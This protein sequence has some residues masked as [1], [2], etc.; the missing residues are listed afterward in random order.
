MGKIIINQAPEAYREAL[1]VG[2]RAG[3]SNQKVDQLPYILKLDEDYEAKVAADRFCRDSSYQDCQKFVEYL[4]SHGFSSAGLAK[5]LTQKQKGPACLSSVPLTPS[6]LLYEE[7]KEKVKMLQEELKAYRTDE[8]IPI[9]DIER[10]SKKRMAELIPVIVG[11]PDSA[12]VNQAIN[13]LKEHAKDQYFNVGMKVKMIDPMIE[14]LLGPCCTGEMESFNRQDAGEVLGVL[15]RQEITNEPKIRILRAYASLL[16]DEDYGIGCVEVK[17]LDLIKDRLFP[18]ELKDEIFDLLVCALDDQKLCLGAMHVISV[19]VSR[20]PLCTP[21]LEKLTPRAM[22]LLNNGD[23]RIRRS[24]AKTLRGI[25]FSN[26]DVYPD[27]G[28]KIVVALAERTLQEKD[29]EVLG[30]IIGCLVGQLSDNT[31]EVYESAEKAVLR[32]IEKGH[33]GV[34]KLVLAK[35][36]EE[37]EIMFHVKKQKRI[38][39]LLKEILSAKSATLP[40]AL[41]GKIKKAVNKFEKSGTK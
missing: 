25:A 41:K 13:E 9:W 11:S 28:V 29:T 21:W 35:L 2:D 40:A 19:I 7:I 3:N 23:V 30:T 27:T 32:V 31:P 14:F 37:I 1:T 39:S 18:D 34:Q 4:S 6:R 26:V 24:A 12:D 20:A 8:N 38:A 10:G 36:L 5:T 22:R 33:P 17:F 16:A 15:L